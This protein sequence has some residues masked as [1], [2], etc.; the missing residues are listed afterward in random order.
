[1]NYGNLLFRIFS[2]VFFMSQ[3]TK[4]M[5]WY[6]SSHVSVYHSKIRRIFMPYIYFYIPVL[7]GIIKL[8]RTIKYK[9]V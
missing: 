1:M 6:Q 5:A 7:F 9:R 3:I 2:Q 8:S 4:I